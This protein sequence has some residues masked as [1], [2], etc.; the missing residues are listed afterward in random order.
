MFHSKIFVLGF[1]VFVSQIRA[2]DLALSRLNAAGFLERAKTVRQPA[3][4][5]APKLSLRPNKK[6]TPFI[7]Q[8]ENDVFSSALTGEK[9]DKNYSNGVKIIKGIRARRLKEKFAEMGMEKVEVSLVLGH[10]LYNPEDK[11]SEEFQADQRRYAGVLYGG[12]K[13][14]IYDNAQEYFTGAHEVELDL[15][16][17]GPS[18][19]AEGLQQ[20]THK[21]SGSTEVNG[22]DHQLEDELFVRLSYLR[23]QMLLTDNEYYQLIG[24]LGASLSNIQ[25]YARAGLYVNIAIF[26]ELSQEYLS[27]NVIHPSQGGQKRV[28]KHNLGITFGTELRAKFHDY[29]VEGNSS[30]TKGLEMEPLVFDLYTKLTYAYKD[31]WSAG[32]I[33]ILRSEEYEGQGESSVLGGLVIER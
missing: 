12:L 2:N 10:L 6:R 19:Q 1:L 29:L 5:T 9:S 15:G 13:L 7:L 3:E 17:V 4:F 27:S 20:F 33:L 28:K 14:N 26:G 21:V 22:W 8:I 16:V 25:S 30:E 32:L 31:K 11:K 24:T 18:A 23:R